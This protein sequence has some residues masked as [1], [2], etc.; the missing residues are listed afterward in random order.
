MK[1]VQSKL[2][3]E[4]KRVATLNNIIKKLNKLQ[5]AEKIK[6]L[7]ASLLTLTVLIAVPVL[8]WFSNQRRIAT[9]AKIN[10]PAKLSIRSGYSEDIIHF[11]MSGINVGSGSSAGS[12]PFVFCIEGEDITNYKIQVAH[13]TNIDFTYKVYKAH[14]NPEGEVVYVDESGTERRYSK[15][16][17]FVTDPTSPCY[18]DYINGDTVGGRI[19]A[20]NHYTE[21]SYDA[22][23]HLQKY[24]EPLYWQTITAIDA[25]GVDEHD[26]SYNEYASFHPDEPTERK[27]LNFYILEV[28]WSADT[29]PNG[30]DKETDLI[31]ITAQVD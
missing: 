10:S 2:A 8:A 30:N 23:E 25:F 13:T 11:Q 28:S 31:Y 9:M 19:I 5:T 22:D 12:Q 14:S 15:S 20:N 4:E 1:Y 7:I 18:G 3:N 29:F 6:I 24:A 16:E 27:F 21:K 26:V 17:E